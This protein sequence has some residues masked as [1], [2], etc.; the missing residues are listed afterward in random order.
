MLG[1]VAAKLGLKAVGAAGSALY[2]A[3]GAVAKT[4]QAFGMAGK[5]LAGSADNDSKQDTQPSNVIV[6]NFGIAGSAGRQRVTGGGTL[7]A[8]KTAAKPQVSAKTPTKALLDTVIKY[9]SSIDKTLKSQIDFDRR[10]LQEQTQ[11]EREAIIE[12]KPSVTFSDLKDRLSGLKSDVKDNASTAATIAKF[13]LVLG[14]AAALIASALDQKELDALKQNV[15]QFKKTF[16]WLGEIGS[17]IPAGGIVGFLFGGK[18]LKGRLIGGLVGI[19]A[20]AVATSIFNKATGQDA[21]AEGGGDNTAINAAALGG[22]GYLGYRGVK[23]GI[24]LSKSVSAI[25]SA[26]A[27]LQA[28]GSFAARRAAVRT[29]AADSAKTG[30]A[31][32]K[33]PMWK[34]FLAFLIARGKTQ[35]VRKIEQRIAIALA[36]GAIAATGVGAA[37]GAIGFLL[38]LGFS[39][40][41]MYEVYQLWQEFTASD[42]ADKAGV[43]D[44]ELEKEISK[45]D[46]IKATGSI[47][48][49]PAGPGNLPA[50]PADIG[51]ILA[52]IRTNESG[53][54]YGE[55]SSK[56]GSSASGAYQFIDST[57]KAQ[58]A[59]AGIGTEYPKAYM[60]PPEVQDAVAANYVKNILKM[61][62]VNGDVSKVPLVW[63]TGNARGAISASAQGVNAVTPQQVQDKF[64]K[65]YDGGKFASS[66]YSS[67]ESASSGIGGMVSAGAGK[68]GEVF[69]MLGSAIVKPGV[70]RSKFTPSAPNTPERINNESTKLQNDITFGIKKE[71]SKDNITMPTLSAGKPRSPSPIKSVSSMDPN[72]GNIDVLSKYLSHFRLA[73]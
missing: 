1:Q 67:S 7:P 72:Y 46:A 70:E 24:G 66:S 59:A 30:L 15:D 29:V 47:P 43:G 40:Y 69:G 26:K 23:A 5:A 2:G 55:N 50:I 52:A 36:T 25:G 19:L 48:G 65:T 16:G 60:A 45:P 22:M 18:G 54:N 33:G 27:G 73:A 31:F 49:A 58:S 34:R 57:W 11:V 62:D 35:L 68:I 8:P 41:F 12:S 14:G 21:T 61:P 28:S 42:T 64:M 71:K 13:A 38:N 63:F 44:A 37:F 3:A 4:G 51:K 39:L 9:L 53:G 17:M 32:L 20:E 10:A 6:G 56:K